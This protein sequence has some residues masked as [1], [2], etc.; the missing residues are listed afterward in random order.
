MSRPMSPC[1]VFALPGGNPAPLVTLAWA[2]HR[3]GLRAT[4]I[5]AV[6]YGSAQQWLRRELHGG[7]QPLAQLRAALGDATLA[8]VMEHPALRPDGSIVEDDAAAEDGDTYRETAWRVARALSADEHTL[9]IAIIEAVVVAVEALWLR[10]L[11][12]I[13]LKTAV[14]TSLIANAASFGVGAL[15][16]WLR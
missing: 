4:E 10:A 8:E 5:H 1:R 9:G 3:E 12:P 7:V 14:L 2:L 15:L 13:G 6:L 11:L 16:W